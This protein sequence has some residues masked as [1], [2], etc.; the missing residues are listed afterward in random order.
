M[1]RPTNLFC[2]LR[3][4]VRH[5]V[6]ETMRTML[7]LCEPD[8]EEEAEEGEERQAEEAPRPRPSAEGRV[9]DGP[10]DHPP[11]RPDLPTSRDAPLQENA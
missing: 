10:T 4:I 5:E 1:P 11:P 7:N 8:E 2:A 3:N 9:S 6:A